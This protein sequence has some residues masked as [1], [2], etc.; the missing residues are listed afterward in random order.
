MTDERTNE[1]I[2]AAIAK[3]LFGLEP[4]PTLAGWFLNAAPGYKG[5]YQ[6]AI[7]ASDH[8]AALGLV[9]PEMRRRGYLFSLEDNGGGES[10]MAIFWSKKF[11]SIPATA[12]YSEEPR[13]ICLAALAVLDA[14]SLPPIRKLGDPGYRFAYVPDAEEAQ[15]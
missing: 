1:E 10:V 6:Q 15:G 9:V 14:E 5:D 11:G 7:Y 8:N 12:P 3:R 4:H 2:S 13:A